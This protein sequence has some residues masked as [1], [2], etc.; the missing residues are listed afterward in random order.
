MRISLSSRARWLFVPRGCAI[1]HVPV[2]NQH[3]I[4]SSLPT[5]HGF[6]PY[7]VPGKAKINNPLPPSTKSKFVEQFEF[8]GTIDNTP[9]LCIPEALKFREEVCG[10][11]EK[12]M[13]YC[14]DVVKAGGITVADILQTE[15]LDN[16]GGS[17]TKCF[18]ANVRLPL[19]IGDARGEVREEDAAAVSQWLVMTMVEDHHTFMA[20]VFY[21]GSWWVRLSGQIYLEAK[22]FEWAGRVMKGL[23]ERVR[24]GDH[25]TSKPCL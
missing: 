15:V 8:V 1:F 2:K 12:I 17:L 19:K 25:L 6:E 13:R 14:T 5:S 20:V 4:R 18:F 7:P 10:G 21:A 9:Y 22:D 3:L 11:E 24:K 16:E 23:C